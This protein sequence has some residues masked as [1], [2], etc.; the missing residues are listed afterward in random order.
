[1]RYISKM[2]KKSLCIAILIGTIGGLTAIGMFSLSGLML[3]KSAYKVPLYTL[4]T[5]V[6]TIKLFGVIRAICKY[7]ERLISHEAT[8]EMLKDIR[9][10]TVR[11]LFDNFITIQAKYQLSTLLNRTVNDIEKLQNL[12]LRVIY[13]PVIALV[14]TLLVVCIYAQ[15]SLYASLV[16][17]L[18][19]LLLTLIL[20]IVVSKILERTVI[21]KIQTTQAF[22]SH[23]LDFHMAN[24]ALKVFDNNN[25]Y[26]QMLYDKQHAMEHAIKKENRILI[27]YDFL[28]NIIAMIAIFLVIVVMIFDPTRDTMMYLSMVMVAIT[29]FEMSIPMVHFPYHKVE[30]DH[31]IA[32]LDELNESS[33]YSPINEPFNRLDLNHINVDHRLNN[34]NLS[35]QKGTFTGIAGPSG[36]G[37]STLIK[38]ILGLISVDGYR[39]NGQKIHHHHYLLE[40]FNVMEQENHFINGTVAENMFGTV[41]KTRL[42]HLL[43]FFNLP[44]DS[45]SEILSFGENLSGGEKKRLHFIRMILR[46]KPIWILDEP[47]NGVDIKNSKIMMDYLKGLSDQTIILVSHDLTMFEQCDAIYLMNE[48]TIVESGTNALLHQNDTQFYMLLQKQLLSI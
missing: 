28:L 46:D 45:D 15:F 37:K 40:M 24:E 39:L 5:L 21:E 9:V 25:V 33:L 32:H 31:A 4:M 22:E 17:A 43:K 36:A 10:M 11:H 48:G 8:F 18:A 1:M 41:D 19:M 44:F 42:N 13:P 30:T 35:I 2:T 23:L 16:L 7:F 12:L 3:S 38:V 29:L 34:I 6:A 27:V 47:F 20:P 14:T 26:Q